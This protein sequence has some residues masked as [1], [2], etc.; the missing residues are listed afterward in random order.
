MSLVGASMAEVSEKADMEFAAHDEI[1][2]ACF[3]VANV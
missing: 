3:D 1:A 2:Y